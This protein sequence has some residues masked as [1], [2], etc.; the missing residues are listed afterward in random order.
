M[1]DEKRADMI[2]DIVENYMES[3]DSKIIRSILENGWVGVFDW[4][5][6][7]LR[8]AHRMLYYEEEE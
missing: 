2:A 5:D 8:E 4:N 3:F 1:N 6:K 7:E